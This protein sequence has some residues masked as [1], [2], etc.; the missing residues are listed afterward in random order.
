M[1]LTAGEIS[2]SVAWRGILAV[3]DRQR[4]NGEASG[5]AL[6]AGQDALGAVHAGAD[7]AGAAV[8][9]VDGAGTV[10]VCPTLPSPVAAMFRLYLPFCAGADDIA[11]AH[12]GQ[13]LDGR[14]ATASGSSHYV[15]G[16]QDILHN[17]RMRALFDAVLVGAR[18][19]RADDP[20]LTVRRCT[21]GNPIRVVIDIERRLSDEFQLFRDGAARTILICAEDRVDGRPRHGMADVLGVPRGSGGLSPR[22]LRTA[23]AGQG[24]RRLFVEGGGITVSRFLEAK[25]LDRLQVTVSPMII[26][27]G[28]AAIVLPEIATLSDSLRPATQRFDFGDDVMFECRF[29]G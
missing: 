20:Q 17:H 29:D 8:A 19:V 3:R 15:T 14:I 28:R 10:R 27:S 11:V 13:S 1:G 21:G 23:L 24:V 2:E 22:T 18:T 12:L 16:V 4:S 6:V 7:P 25:C 26:G 9:Q 5:W